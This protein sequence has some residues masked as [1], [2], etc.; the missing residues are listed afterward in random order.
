ALAALTR[1]ARPRFG[2][3]YK[4]IYLGDTLLLGNLTLN[5][6]GRYDWQSAQNFA[7]EVPA[8]PLVP[9][10]LPA[11]SFP[12]DEKALEW[13]GF[14]PR[15]GATYAFGKDKR[16][17]ARA[18]YSHYINQIGSSD[19][20]TANPFYRVQYLYYYW[21][22]LNGD[23]SV[24]RNEID[25]DSGVY[26]FDNIDPNNTGSGYAPGRLD[27]NMKPPKTDEL[28]GGVQYELFNGF[29]VGANYTYR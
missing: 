11:A 22:D 2:S 19:A 3:K 16:A 24:Q 13:N 21:D 17:I 8:N 7:S 23:R 25:F 28:I 1:D 4:D 6:G 26:S 14:A 5:V 12:G 20:G 29:A 27:Y 10:I 15:L 9:D 18:S